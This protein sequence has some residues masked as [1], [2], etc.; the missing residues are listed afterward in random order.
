MCAIASRISGASDSAPSASA[1]LQGI[2]LGGIGVLEPR[3]DRDAVPGTRQHPDGVARL[4]HAPTSPPTGTAP[5]RPSRVKRFTHCGSRILRWKV[6]ARLPRAR[7]LDDELVAD[8]PPLADLRAVD[9][10]PGRPQVLAE[11]PRRGCRGPAPAPRSQRPPRRTRTAP[12]TRPPWCF[13]S[14]CTSPYKPERTHPQ[15]LL[16]RS[17]VDGRDTDRFPSRGA[18][19]PPGTPRES[20]PSHQYRQGRRVSGCRASS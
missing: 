3:R 11:Q 12:S 16:H 5:A 14:A 17:L 1:R 6:A 18:A 19:A 9:I 2:R 4:R 8:R 15:T 20:L 10:D 13:R 7:H